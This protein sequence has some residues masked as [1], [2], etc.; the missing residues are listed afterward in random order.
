LRGDRDEG[1]LFLFAGIG[2]GE[3]HHHEREH[4]LG[5]EVAIVNP[6]PPIGGSRYR[7]FTMFSNVWRF[8]ESETDPL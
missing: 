2:Q 7:S 3:E 1:Q 8:Q 4:A 6:E 5:L